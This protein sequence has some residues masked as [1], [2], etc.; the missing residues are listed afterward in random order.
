VLFASNMGFPLR[1]LS[2][3]LSQPAPTV[4]CIFQKGASEA[5]NRQSDVAAKLKGWLLVLFPEAF[6][7]FSW[8]RINVFWTQQ[9]AEPEKILLELRHNL[10]LT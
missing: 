5:W 8:D 6:E 3:S 10:F 2:F 1:S 4:H 7:Y 9:C